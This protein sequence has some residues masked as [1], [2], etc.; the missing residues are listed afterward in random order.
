M[1]DSIAIAE[2]A[3]LRAEVRALRQQLQAG[4]L[5][6]V[7]ITRNT[8]ATSI[9]KAVGAAHSAYWAACDAESKAINPAC[10][11]APE[12]L[13]NDAYEAALH[14]ESLADERGISWPE[15]R[16]ENCISGYAERHTPDPRCPPPET[17]PPPC[18]RSLKP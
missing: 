6:P 1:T 17:I 9:A 18:A 8:A 4:I 16:A 7:T 3:N 2:I 11:D 15:A 10:L 14:V 12:G 5:L 13:L